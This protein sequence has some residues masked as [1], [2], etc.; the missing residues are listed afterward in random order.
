MEKAKKNANKEF[1]L[2]SW[3]IDNPSVI[4]VMIGIFLIIGIS[5]YF[6]MPREEFPEAVETKIY[7]ST[8]YPG[9]TAEDMER[10]I[11]DPLEDRL[12]D[13]SNFVEMTS[14]SQE[15]YSMIVVEFDEDITVENAK[16]EVKDEVDAEKAGEDWPIFNGAKV[17]PNVFDLNL[18]ESFPILNVNMKGDY[19]VEKLKEYAEY[20]EDE[21][22][23][24][25]EIKQVDIRGAQEKEVEVA[26]D[27]NKMMA[28]KVNF[29][30]IIDAIN[31]GNMTMSAGNLI[32]SGQRR[33]IR[34]T[35]E[36]E[37]PSEL[38]DFVVK[39]DNGTVYLRDIAEVTFAEEDKN[40]YARE[41]GE[42]V[43][44]LDIKKRSGK[45]DVI[46]TEKRRK[47]VA[48][49]QVDFLAEDLEVTFANDSSSTPL[50]HV[51]YL[52]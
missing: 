25:D 34:I 28:A 40:T 9:N 12:K 6:S 39:S 26:V 38:N 19:P 47:I 13:V 44:M 10:L 27:I 46:A 22:E 11:T 18:A 48:E 24:L 50:H 1:R 49:A 5:S 52:V 8:I 2:S 23:N 30:G 42:S 35:G 17:E 29:Q 37:R 31:N 20:L 21:I 41:M 7:V 43:V 4:Y 33:T 32:T 15:D 16:Q 14:T 3:A 51:I 45:N 36:I